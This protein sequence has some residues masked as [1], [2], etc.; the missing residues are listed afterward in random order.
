M[1]WCTYD[2]MVVYSGVGTV[3]QMA[4]APG[5]AQSGKCFTKRFALINNVRVASSTTPCWCMPEAIPAI[6]LAQSNK[7]S[8][9]F[10]ALIN[11]VAHLRLHL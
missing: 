5:P 9:K 3:M 7:R 8:T 1:V 2:N 4:V 6:G 11:G 10:L